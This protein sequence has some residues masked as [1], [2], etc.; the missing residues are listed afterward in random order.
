MKHK[1]NTIIKNL[2][3]D[4]SILLSCLMILFAMIVYIGYLGLSISPREISI[5]NRYAAFGDELYYRSEWYYL[6][7]FIALAVVIAL[8]HIILIIKLTQRNLRP[9][10]LA[11]AWLT[12]IIFAILAL[13]THSI[14]YLV[15]LS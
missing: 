1:V 4:R 3:A 6:F 5:V 8:A 14:L 9:F 11:L 7:N 13:V 10:A 15:H 12:M 2:L